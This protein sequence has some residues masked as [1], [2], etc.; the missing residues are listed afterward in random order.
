MGHAKQSAAHRQARRRRAA[1]VAATQDGI[2]SRRQL[3]A[4]GVL[5]SEIR[6]ERNAGRWQRMGPQSLRVAPSSDGTARWW[7]ALI[8]VAPGAVLDGISAL[9]AE[10]LKTIEEDRIHVAVPKSAR[11]RRVRGVRVHETRRFCAEDVVT[12]G[13]PRMKPAT[14]VVHAVL[15]A[16]S[17][18]QAS[19][20]VVAAVQQGLVRPAQLA[21]E[22]AKV[23]RHRRRT[24]LAALVLDVTSGVQSMGELDFA[25]LCD[26]RGFP[27]PDR[28]V[29]RRGANGR[30]YLDADWLR[31]YVTVEIDGIQHLDAAAVIADALKQ[32]TVALEGGV[33]LRI[34]LLALRSDPTPF[35]DQVE[36]ALRQGGWPGPN[37]LRPKEAQL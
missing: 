24:L 32:N 26:E 4:I 27:P 1:D 31:F 10:G 13:V 2:L 12:S 36:A 22:V 19:L 37:S 8:E 7:C 25:R 6:A 14:A 11:P 20:Y 33:V 18:R 35:M 9:V 28:Q 17:N 16:R 30:I 15:W 3:Y 21:V 5:R 34:P 29:M 23:R